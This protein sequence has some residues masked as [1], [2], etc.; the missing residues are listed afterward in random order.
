MLVE[1][2]PRGRLADSNKIHYSPSELQ[3]S[4]SRRG[5]RLS[6]SDIHPHASLV[7]AHCLSAQQLLLRLQDA[8]DWFYVLDVWSLEATL[9]DFT[10]ENSKKYSL[11]VK[12]SRLWLYAQNTMLSALVSHDC[13]VS[14]H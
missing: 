14:V 5:V 13:A 6:V 10:L 9:L 3:I 11:L 12:D 8:Q 2:Y 4:N 1:N 7:A